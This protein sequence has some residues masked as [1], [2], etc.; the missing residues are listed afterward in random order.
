MAGCIAEFARFAQ[1]NFISVT[2]SYCYQNNQP[3][4]LKRLVVYFIVQYDVINS[5]DSLLNFLQK[6]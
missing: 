5:H 1:I 2:Y 4:K 3:K 6:H